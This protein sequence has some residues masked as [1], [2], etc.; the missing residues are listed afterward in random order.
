MQRGKGVMN[1]AVKVNGRGVIRNGRGGVAQTLALC[2]LALGENSCLIPYHG[3][4]PG[5][6]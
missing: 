1:E 4:D 2:E 3:L 5:V 6:L